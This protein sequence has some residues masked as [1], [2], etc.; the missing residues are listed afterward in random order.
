MKTISN[1]V[2]NAFN[3]GDRKTFEYIFETYWDPLFLH[4][5]KKTGNSQEAEDLV[6][7]IFLDLWNKRT[8][9]S[10]H[11]NLE[12]YLYTAVKYKFYKSVRNKKIVIQSF[13]GQEMNIGIQEDDME[14]G[15]MYEKIQFTV[16]KLPEKCR[17]VF[18]LS[19]YELLSSKEIAQKLSLSPQTVNN[20]LS[21]SMSIIKREMKEY[22]LII[23][24][25]FL[26]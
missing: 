18:K 10:I 20:R 11:T 8:Q 24:I 7:D 26:S 13:D 16:E 14:F 5:L 9:I 19:R 1:K 21:M 15:E 22:P 4:T 3:N 2:L 25:F 23:L 6:Q 12:S 17:E